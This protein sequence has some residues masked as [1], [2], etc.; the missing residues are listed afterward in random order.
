VVWAVTALLGLADGLAAVAALLRNTTTLPLGLLAEEFGLLLLE[1]ELFPV[2][3]TETL[4]GRETAGLAGLLRR[5]ATLGRLLGVARFTNGNGGLLGRSGFARPGL[6]RWRLGETLGR[7]RGLGVGRK[8]QHFLLRGRTELRLGS[9]R[10]LDPRLGNR[11]GRHF[12]G[13]GRGSLNRRGL[14]SRSGLLAGDAGR[15]HGLAA[16]QA[17]SALLRSRALGIGRGGAVIGVLRR[18][19]SFHCGTR[20]GRNRRHCA[21]RVR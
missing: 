19:R 2:L 4:A 17:R 15:S 3:A 11:G 6:L 9:R 14:G 18:A 7:R 13:G 21:R 8:R 12:C 5:L 20:N 1:L 10:T 16:G